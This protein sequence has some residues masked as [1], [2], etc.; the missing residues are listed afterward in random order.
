MHP[1][2]VA[3][4][5][6]RLAP[7]LSL[8]IDPDNSLMYLQIL[9]D[10]RR[11][12]RRYFSSGFARVSRCSSPAGSGRLSGGPLC[13]RLQDAV[14]RAFGDSCASSDGVLRPGGCSPLLRPSLVGRVP[15]AAAGRA[16]SSARRSSGYPG[17]R[18]SLR[19]LPLAALVRPQSLLRPPVRGLSCGRALPLASR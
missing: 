5:S 7:Y 10:T 12:S 1:V 8:G 17:R 11:Y 14:G 9:A 4:K 13:H 2:C 3:G 16:S 6:T 15:P 18:T 19:R